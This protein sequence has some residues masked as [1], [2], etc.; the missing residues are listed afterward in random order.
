MI[1]KINFVVNETKLKEMAYGDT[2]YAWL[3]LHSHY[4]PNENHNYIY[5]NEFT[6]TMIG[7]DIHRTRQT[8]SKR[9]NELLTPTISG[10]DLLYY[11]E[12]HKVYILPNFREFEKLDAETVLNLFWLCGQGN[13]KRKEELIKT[14][15]WL[16]KNFKE[17]KKEISF[18]DLIRAFGHTKGNEQ[19]YD[20]YKDI[21]TTLQGAGLIKFKTDLASQ[22]PSD[23]RFYKTYYIYQVND[24]AS[25]EWIDKKG[26]K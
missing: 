6:F 15:A 13:K 8:V 26:G 3:L 24:K 20:R 21:L 1:N 2:V 5:A 17:K 25:Q 19:T 14:Y 11:D 18:D 4:N 10:K 9:F 22:R 7:K 12:Y 16:K 23:G